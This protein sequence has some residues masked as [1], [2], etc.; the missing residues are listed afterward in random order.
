MQKESIVSETTIAHLQ[1]VAEA[2]VRLVLTG[3]PTSRNLAE[4]RYREQTRQ[5]SSPDAAT[6]AS[7]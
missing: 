5:G 3:E 7:E 6:Q 1:G 4:Q 2:W